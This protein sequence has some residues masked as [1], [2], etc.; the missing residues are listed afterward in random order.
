MRVKTNSIEKIDQSRSNGLDARLSNGKSM[1]VYPPP[2]NV[3]LVGRE[4]E[5]RQRHDDESG[6]DIQ[7]P[8]NR[9]RDVNTLSK[10]QRLP[11][12]MLRPNLRQTE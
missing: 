1:A 3:Y 8:K 5:S 11:F 7:R 10:P 9:K 4:N 12:E 6:L 2:R